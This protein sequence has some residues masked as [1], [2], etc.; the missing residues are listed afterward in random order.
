LRGTTVAGIGQFA[1]VHSLGVE[2][3]PV[4][5]DDTAE[6]ERGVAAFAR[7]GNS[8]L[9]VTAASTGSRRELIIA[10]A[11]RFRLP[12]DLSLSLLR[13]DGAR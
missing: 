2:L 9:I 13:L 7:S 1:A 5:V 11:F 12:A 6:M 4:A 3:T 8:G 10:L